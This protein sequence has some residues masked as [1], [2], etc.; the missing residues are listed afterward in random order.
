MG[1]DCVH[2]E[3]CSLH[4]CISIHAPRMGGDPA[5]SHVDLRQH[6]SIHAPRMGG[7]WKPLPIG[8]FAIDFN[9]RPPHG[10]RHYGRMDARPAILFQSTPPAWGATGGRTSREP[11][12]R[13]FNPRPPHGGRLHYFPPNY[14]QAKFQSTP[15]AWGA[16]RGFHPQHAAPLHF[17][18]RPP[19]GGRPPE[20]ARGI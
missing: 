11:L 20:E 5:E 17:N 1:G 3:F 6:I 8:P 4:R 18:P 14:I 10:G 15:P 13:H 9:P 12:W 16:T 7:D 19:H 2:T